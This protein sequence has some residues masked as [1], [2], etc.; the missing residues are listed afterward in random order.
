MIWSDIS[1]IPFGLDCFIDTK[2]IVRKTQII[3]YFF[4]YFITI[5]HTY[6][7]L[8]L[9]SRERNKIVMNHD[10][11]GLIVKREDGSEIVNYDDASF[12]S[13]IFDGWVAPKVTWERVPH[14][15]EDVEIVTVT[16]GNMA[17]SVNG[18]TLML[19]A[20]DTIFVN[21]N[22]IHYSMAL[23]GECAKYVIFIAHPDILNSSL[24]VQLSALLPIISNPDLPYLRFRDINRDTEELYNLMIGLPAIKHDPF[25]V[26][27][28]FFLIWEIIMR[29]S[30]TIGALEKNE[31][32][33]SHM[34]VFKTMM[35]FIQ[36]EYTHTITLDQ[37]AQSGNISKSLCNNLFKQY[38]EESP[39][40][41][42]LHF[43]CRKVAEY[44]RMGNHT[45]T[46]IASLTGFCGVSYMSETFKKYFG[47]S[48]REYKKKWA[49]VAAEEAAAML[50]REKK[51]Q[52]LCLLMAEE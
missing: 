7:R 18:K 44:L 50:E 13:Y 46:E 39:I 47:S 51:E 25:Q 52:G 48:P 4:Q 29:Q 34:Q 45:L 6:G 36:R 33:D 23:D 28:N 43:R 11:M 37:I 21:S 26:T 3:G 32:S 17:Y 22:Q 2:Y 30:A 8:L 9:F 38:V 40:N 12:P 15:H 14:F 16:S 1:L 31:N 10:V 49:N 41:Y 35:Y 20:G 42:L 19:H 5:L 24:Q 27:K